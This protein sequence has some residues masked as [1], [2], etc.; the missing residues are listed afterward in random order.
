MYITLVEIKARKKKKIG[1]EREDETHAGD[2]IAQNSKFTATK[3][4]GKIEGVALP[5]AMDS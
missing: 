3:I 4:A 5:Y 2:R 1:D